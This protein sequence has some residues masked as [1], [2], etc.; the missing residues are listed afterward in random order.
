M[1]FVCAADSAVVRRTL[2]DIPLVV[3]L[4]STEVVVFLS[5]IACSCSTDTA[6]VRRILDMPPV[7]DAAV[8]LRRD[9][10][11]CDDGFRCGA[12][13]LRVHGVHDA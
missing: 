9:C 11:F 10:S 12:A 6:V 1:V 7:V 3:W 5:V 4:L 13:M 8:T 2:D